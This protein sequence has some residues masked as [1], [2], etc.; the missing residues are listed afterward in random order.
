MYIYPTLVLQKQSYPVL[1]TL[2]DW[3]M[4]PIFN[5]SLRKENNKIFPH[6]HHKG[7]I[8]FVQLKNE[9]RV[10]TMGLSVKLTRTNYMFSAASW[11]Q[12]KTA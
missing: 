7:L 3:L 5:A 6:S 10:Q 2:V 1:L 9:P 4:H 11:Q 8:I 12:Q